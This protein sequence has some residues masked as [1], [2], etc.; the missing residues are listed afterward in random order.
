VSTILTDIRFA[1]RSLLHARGFTA[2]AILT[3]GLGLMLC[4][5]TMVVVNA[6][7]FTDLPYP[8]ANRLY[9]VRYA[10]PGQEPPRNMETLDW[11]SLDDLIEHPIAWD[12]DVFYLLGGENAERIP[13]AWVT[14]GFVQGLGIHPVVGRGFDAAA[15]TPGTDNVALISHRLWH[16]RYGGDPDVVGR[17][18]TAYVSDRPEETE[19]FTIIGVLPQGLWHFNSYTDILSPLRAPTYPYMVRLRDG[20]APETAGARITSHVRQGAANV[21]PNWT[22][23]V[24]SAHRQYVATVRPLLRTVTAAAVLVLLVACGNVATLLLIRTTRRQKELAVRS[25]LGAG[26]W[27]I[28]RTLVA[29][30]L[31]L[32]AAASLLALVATRLT[33]DS[34]APLVQQQLGRN[35][36]GGAAALTVD[37]RVLMAVAGAGMLTAILCAAAPLATSLRP[38]LLGALQS[39]GRTSTESAGTQRIRASLIALEIAASL[40][41][42]VGSTLMLRTVIILLNTE[43]GFSGARILNTSVTLRQNRYPDAA[44][45]LPVWERLSARLAGL[46]GAESVGLTTAW[47]LQQGRLRLVDTP[48][49][50]QPHASA[51]AAVQGV[52]DS[53]FATL[54]IPI[55]AGRAFTSADRVGTDAVALVSNTLAR[56]LW[57]E[58]PAIG[59]R[60]VVPQEQ[61][62]GDPLSITR[63]VVGVVGDV[64]QVPDD[65]DLA[66]VYVPI[67][68]TPGRFGLVLMRTAGAPDNW[69]APVRAAFRDI[70]PEIAVERGR[71][72]SIAMNE[73]T[74]RPRFLARLLG[75]FAAIAALL[76]LVGTYGVIAYTV[77]QREREIAIRL[78]IGGDPARITRL[79]LRQGGWILLGGLALGLMGA[80]GAGRVIESQLYGVTPHDPV[81]LVEAVAAFASAGLFAIWWPARRAAATDPAIAL[82]S[83]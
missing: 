73:A 42:V 78:A 20:V 17:T 28:A 32:G 74:S 10:A 70:D 13:G 8:A 67:F 81:A 1:V 75:S 71:P 54:D 31:V 49:G 25:A 3:L 80:L 2:T 16:S 4:A 46:P 38:R 27:A 50:T 7:L 29:E 58:G 36:P 63:V 76:A 55:L 11:S 39:G 52:N 30:A 40:T 44:S 64:H 65:A 15:F 21:P 22:A 66:D 83:E 72:L 48:P 9:T 82:R 41:L 59:H 6:Y 69:L 19:R 26:R 56:R 53:Y 57:P 60:I 68:Q 35:V 14:P 18:F 33:L 62:G 47:P 34:I 23:D 24:V 77:R 37:G 61:D 12:L 51:Q 45:R 43:L 5:T 79:F